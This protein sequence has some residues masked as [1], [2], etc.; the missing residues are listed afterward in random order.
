MNKV[1][2]SMDVYTGTGYLLRTRGYR[3]GAGARVSDGFF[4]T[5]G[6]KPVL[7]RDFYAG[8]DEPGA[9]DG[10]AELR[11]V[12]AAVRRAAGIIGEADHA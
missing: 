1:F 7:G 6:V 8:E 3:T 5:L 2:S 9:A 11:G 12:A 10:D 4:R